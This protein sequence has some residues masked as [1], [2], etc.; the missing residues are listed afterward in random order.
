MVGILPVMPKYSAALALAG[1]VVG[2]D[3]EAVGP[4]G[5]VAG[6]AGVRQG[7]DEIERRM[8]VAGVEACATGALTA[9]TAMMAARAAAPGMTL[10]I[11][12]AVLRWTGM[13]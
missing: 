3:I 11:M 2:L 8:T 7:R 13:G 6:R 10:R 9:P 12:M 5:D 4:E 1:G